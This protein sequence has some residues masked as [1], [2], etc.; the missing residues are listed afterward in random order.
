[1]TGGRVVVVGGGLAGIAAAVALGEAGVGVTLLEARPR[2][3]GAT[4]SFERD[5]LTLDNGQHVF[6]RCCTAYQGLLDRLGQSGNVTIQDRFDVPIIAPGGVSAR[7]RRDRLPGPFHLTRALA[8]YPLL[9]PAERARAATASLALGRLD[10]ADPELDE[11]RL[12]DWLA[13]HGQT[14]RARRVLWDLFVVAS[15]NIAGDDAPLGLAAKV[16]QTALLGRADAADIGVPAVPLGK[17]HGEAAAGLLARQRAD[18]RLGA[19]VVGVR[20]ASSGAGFRV[21]I[22][23]E[24]LAADGV[25][26]AVPPADAARLVPPGAAEGSS[27]WARLGTSP[28]VNLHVVYDR[29]VMRQPFVAAVDS[30]VQWVFD[31][32]GPAGVEKG[33][34]LAVSLSAADTYLERRTA[35]LRAEFVPALAALFP[36]ARQ[37]RVREFFVTK[38]PQATFRQTPGTRSARSGAA[39][40][41]PGLAVA[42][43][44][45]DTGWPDTMEGAV[46]SGLTAAKLVK[47]SL[48][49][50]RTG[51]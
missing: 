19:K 38:Q 29:P 37:E 6:L 50:S 30:P 44:W 51:E 26:L 28:I 40:R 15:L 12:G 3:G 49:V 1:M 31:R 48:A 45:T 47:R 21:A 24:E 2:L 10:P 9:T 36:A 41:L 33:Q 39:T 14:T 35:E 25:V 42:G 34:Y 18:V 8:A 5:G 20:P 4:H 16:V 46:R 11:I 22:E 43:A 32:T 17:L 7:L 27:E 13:A 23:G